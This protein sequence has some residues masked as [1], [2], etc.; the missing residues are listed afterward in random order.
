DFWATWCG[1]CRLTAPTLSAWQA[2]YGAQGLSVVGIT[3]DEAIE[4]ATFARKHSMRF[5]V[6]S[7]AAAET[8]HA[9]GVQALPTLFVIDRRGVVRDVA[10]GYDPDREAQVEALVRTLLAESAPSN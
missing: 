7:D 5:T 9:Y 8:S 4:A 2:R 1:P 10:I 3:T 6:A